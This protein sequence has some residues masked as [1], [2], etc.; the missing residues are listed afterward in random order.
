MSYLET[1]VIF[2]LILLEEVKAVDP[3]VLV[4][5]LVEVE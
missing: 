4:K 3:Q 1:N 2:L 5:I